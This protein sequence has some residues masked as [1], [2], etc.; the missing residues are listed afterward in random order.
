[1]SYDT[2]RKDGCRLNVCCTEAVIE[3]WKEEEI[4]LQIGSI[5]DDKYEILH[6][7]GKGGTAKVYLA[8]NTKMNQQ[9]VVKE[10]SRKIGK[11]KVKQVLDEARLMMEFDHPAI[12]RIVDIH[13]DDPDAVYIIMDY[14]SGQSLA[15]FIKENG[16]QPQKQVEAWGLQICD[17]FDYL[18][19]KE[20]P[21][22]YHDLKPG[23]LILKQPENN[24]KLIDFGEA[25]KLVNGQATGGGFTPG[26]A[27][28]E[29]L[30]NLSPTTD[31]NGK[32][33][34]RRYRDNIVGVPEFEIDSILENR[35]DERS[36][37]YCIGTT[38]Y[39]LLTGA[40]PPILPEQ[41]G[42]VRERFPELDITN[43]MDNIIQKCTEIDP[44]DRFQSIQELK[45]A[46]IDIDLWDSKY[47]GRMYHK[48]KIF[49]AV[50]VMCVA[51]LVGGIACNRIS[52]HVKNQ[53]Y[54]IL[55]STD[56]GVDYETKLA[57]YIEAIQIDGSDPR[58]YSK[59]LNA[60]IENESFGDV[61][62]QQFISLYNANKPN[63]DMTSKEI[64]D[65]NFEIGRSYFNL[66]TGGGNSF[67][68]RLQKASIYFGYIH[69]NSQG[70]Y[71]NYSICE[72]YYTLCNFYSRFV[73]NKQGGTF[74]AEQQDYEE[75]LDVIKPCLNDMNTYQSSD[76]AYVH[77]EMEKELLNMIDSNIT[78]FVQRGVNQTTVETAIQ[79]IVAFAS[80]EFVT[81]EENIRTQASIL[82]QAESISEHLERQYTSSERMK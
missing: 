51:L 48:I 25:R 41:I 13:D 70:S 80:K 11:T 61:E 36:D 34:S 47:L 52:A 77:F 69:D 55:I 3:I 75:M 81:Q 14:I 19:T 82:V 24:L 23:N 42:S 16:L 33:I 9:W 79:E 26:Y 50:C 65:L 5:L 49:A 17:V 10:V 6:R 2:C 38:M 12:P 54:D 15:K 22:V 43:G 64:L 74:E 32:I 72:S 37:I 1:M 30:K 20:N 66:Y 35:T 44:D 39:R 27:A 76:S 73:L 60:Y 63:F 71:E 56:A 67:R 31:K 58:A 21:V 68:D 7:I 40:F 57:N 78:G 62:S 45:K 4:M 28:P 53:N 18:H 59:L 8:M 29:Q 46:L